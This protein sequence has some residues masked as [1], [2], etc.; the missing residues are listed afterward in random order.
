[1]NKVLP[2]A[3]KDDRAQTY[4]VTVGD[5]ENATSVVLRMGKDYYIGGDGEAYLYNSTRV[6]LEA[7]GQET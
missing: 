7:K 3:I 5:D 4:T 2:T 1:M 6:I